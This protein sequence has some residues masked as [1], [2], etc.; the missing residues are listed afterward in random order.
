[1]SVLSALFSRAVAFKDTTL[2]RLLA[3][4]YAYLLHALLHPTQFMLVI[5]AKTVSMIKRTPDKRQTEHYQ[6]E[7]RL[8]GPM[9]KLVDEAIES[10]ELILPLHHDQ[11]TDRLH[12]LGR[13]FWCDCPA[14]QQRRHVQRKR[15]ACL[16][17]RDFQSRQP[18][19]GWY[20]LA[21]FEQPSGLQ[22]KHQ[23]HCF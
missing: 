18:V 5:S 22:R 17:V 21:P 23:T 11:T 19:T 16:S 1:M 9:L 4:Q 13:Q 3:V 15:V 12:R 6:L 14:N 10:N 8:M 2:E 20:A 7:G